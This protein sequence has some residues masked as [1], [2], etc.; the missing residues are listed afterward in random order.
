MKI[1]K[2]KTEYCCSA[3]RYFLGTCETFFY[4]WEPSDENESMVHIH[5]KT[6]S[7]FQQ[8]DIYYC[9]FCGEKI[10]WLDDT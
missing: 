3:F 5:F 8:F 2:I 6:T 4:E 9:P 10:E 7:G 1:N